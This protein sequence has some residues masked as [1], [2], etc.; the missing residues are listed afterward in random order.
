[1]YQQVNEHLQTCSRRPWVCKGKG[2]QKKIAPIFWSDLVSIWYRFG[3]SYIFGR[4]DF[5]NSSAIFIT[6]N[7]CC[8]NQ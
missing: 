2:R 8:I 4:Y 5:P 6:Q 3:I 7:A 1:M